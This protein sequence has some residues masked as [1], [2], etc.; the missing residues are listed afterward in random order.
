MAEGRRGVIGSEE[1]RQPPRLSA[2][3][4]GWMPA[5]RVCAGTHPGRL[6]GYLV[7]DFIREVSPGE[8]RAGFYSSQDPWLSV[9]SGPRKTS[10]ASSIHSSPR[11]TPDA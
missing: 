9:H 4:P 8:K 2:L 7:G 5:D 6:G 11:K 3:G 10:D 1:E